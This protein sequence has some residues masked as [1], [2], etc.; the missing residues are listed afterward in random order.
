MELVLQAR[1]NL[2]LFYALAHIKTADSAKDFEKISRNFKCTYL[3]DTRWLINPHKLRNRSKHKQSPSV[4]DWCSN[5]CAN[6]TETLAGQSQIFTKYSRSHIYI[7]SQQ[8]QRKNKFT[9]L[10]QCVTNLTLFRSFD[11]YFCSLIYFALFFL[12]HYCPILNIVTH[13]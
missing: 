2:F 3:L 5:S 12:T 6:H 4:T 10:I 13:S 7:Q 9:W 8:M 1:K 11:F